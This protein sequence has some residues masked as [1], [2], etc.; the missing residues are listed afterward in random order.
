LSVGFIHIG[1]GICLLI[2]FYVAVKIFSQ[3]GITSGSSKR[4]KYNFYLLRH[5]YHEIL[6]QAKEQVYRGQ[7][8]VDFG[9]KVK[10]LGA[11]RKTVEKGLEFFQDNVEGKKMIDSINQNIHKIVNAEADGMRAKL[12]EREKK[13]TKRK[14][15]SCI[16]DSIKYIKKYRKLLPDDKD[17]EAFYW[18]LTLRMVE[19]KIAYYVQDGCRAMLRKKY[20]AGEK[21]FA[22]AIFHIESLAEDFRRP[23]LTKHAKMQN[24]IRG[25]R[26]RKQAI[27]LAKAES[28]MKKAA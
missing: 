15:E 6:D 26:V 1:I 24:I 19:N 13:I 21:H 3:K 17:W 5:Q 8:A 14:F 12:A 4:I 16:I 9:Q 10:I 20:K 27:A 25:V 11:A 28:K 23:H 22:E 7:Q 18:E 2:V